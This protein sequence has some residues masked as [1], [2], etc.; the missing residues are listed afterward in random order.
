MFF[1]SYCQFLVVR[2]AFFF[3]VPHFSITR[4][5]LLSPL[6]LFSSLPSSSPPLKVYQINFF[7]LF[8]KTLIIRSVH[9]PPPRF[10]H[11]IL[12]FQ[13]TF[14]LSPLFSSAHFY[15]HNYNQSFG[16]RT[17]PIHPQSFDT[18]HI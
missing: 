5:F 11:Q 1:F 12:F 16:T 9:Q 6:P 3:L 14:L 10:S 8:F 13:Q 7:F 15:Y 4:S 17:H 2:V 18:T